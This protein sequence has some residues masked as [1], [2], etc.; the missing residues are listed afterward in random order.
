M[1]CS[2]ELSESADRELSKLDAQ[3]A[4]R[5]LKFLHER[6][7]KL[8]D[9]RSIGEALHGSRLGEFWKYRVGDYRLIA[10]IEDDRLVV[11]ASD[12]AGKSIASAS[13]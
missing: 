11:L 12:T 2:V 13:A 9:P 7:A 10:K 6:V 8:D 4:K 1:D 3:Q 5:I